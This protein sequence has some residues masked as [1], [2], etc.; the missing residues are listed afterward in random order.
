MQNI[1]IRIAKNLNIFIGILLISSSAFF[2]S[3]QNYSLSWNIPFFILPSLCVVGAIVAM[4]LNFL[5]NEAYEDLDDKYPSPFYLRHLAT[6]KALLFAPVPLIP[7][8][9]TISTFIA[10]YPSLLLSFNLLGLIGMLI[11][12]QQVGIR[13]RHFKATI[14]A[15]VNVCLP[16]IP[17]PSQGKI[18]NLEPIFKGIVLGGILGGLGVL[19]FGLA[20]KFSPSFYLTW[21]NKFGVGIT[22]IGSQWLLAVSAIYFCRGVGAVIG[23]LVCRNNPEKYGYHSSSLSHVLNWGLWGA[24]WGMSARDLYLDISVSTKPQNLTRKSESISNSGTS[25]ESGEIESGVESLN[26]NPYKRPYQP[27]SYAQNIAKIGRKNLPVNQ[28][29]KK[30]EE[31]SEVWV[32]EPPSLVVDGSAGE[33]QS[34]DLTADLNLLPQAQGYNKG[35]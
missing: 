13:G 29:Q 16:F 30:T 23:A 4:F 9:P 10:P 15:A 20:I 32:Q 34:R 1:R 22:T 18:N 8:I 3:F 27:T 7:F 14:F 19:S 5:I 17:L 12:A 6:F 26:Q 33:N 31:V 21:T 11:L 28:K 24:I 2:S 35:Q 25:D